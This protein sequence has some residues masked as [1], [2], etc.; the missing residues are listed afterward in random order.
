MSTLKVGINGFGRIGRQVFKALLERPA[1]D[2]EV[3]AVNDLTDAKTLAYLLKY[4]S[5][6]GRFNRPVEVGENCLIVDG[7]RIRLSS[8]RDPSKIEWGAIGVDVVLESTGYFTKGED[9]SAHLT[10]GAKKVLISAPAKGQFDG[11]V[12]MG[13]NDEALLPSWRVFS[14]ASCTTN[15]AALMVKGVHDALGVKHA[16]ITVIHAYTNDQ[17]LH[18][19]PHSE[20]R[21]ARAAAVSLVPASTGSSTDIAKVIPALRG[22]LSSV[23]IRTPN[24]DGSIVDLVC[25]VE[26]PASVE[27]INAAFRR[28]QQAR[29]DLVQCTDD[30]IVS[31]DVIG[32]PASVIIDTA[33]TSVV[34]ERLVKVMG[35]FDNEWGYSNRC[36]DLLSV[37]R[38][39]RFRTV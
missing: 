37:L 15:C 17:S 21:R 36:A 39:P 23:A 38:D 34:D 33:L 18:D 28:M 1:Q 14:N 25:E 3:V 30:P 27:E 4:D 11:T 5:V 12:V 8:Q 35:W 2:V 26:K 10:A 22:K 6:H 13:V 9:A 24:I 32:N 16:A 19:Q 31:I 29:P 7:R 20:L